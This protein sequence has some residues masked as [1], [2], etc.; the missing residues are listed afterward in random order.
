MKHIKQW[1]CALLAPVLALCLL[2]LPAARAATA[3]ELQAAAYS[4]YYDFL[5]AEISRIGIISNCEQYFKDHMYDSILDERPKGLLY[6]QLIDF[7]NSGVDELLIVKLDDDD[8]YGLGITDVRLQVYAYSGGK[9]VKIAQPSISDD[10]PD[11]E[12]TLTTG[13]DGRSYFREYTSWDRSLSYDYDYYTVVNGQWVKRYA[14]SELFHPDIYI[15]SEIHSS[16]G[17]YT[18]TLDNQSI[19]RD[20]YYGYRDQLD[21]TE[22][23]YSYTTL[24]SS[25]GDPIWTVLPSGTVT[26][27]MNTLR[28]YASQDTLL[29]YAPPASW[30]AEQVNAG[31]ADGIV[32]ASL[33]NSYA[34]PITR[35]EFCALAV[36]FYEK[37]TGTTIP[38]TASFS[39]T[40]DANVRKM[41]S[42]GV[43]NGIGGDK[44]APNQP[45]TREQAAVIPLPGSRPPS[46]WATWPPLWTIPSPPAP[47]PSPTTPRS[48]AGPAPRW[49]RCRP[50]ALWGA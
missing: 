20:Q 4:A 50:P 13:T 26:S 17:R 18:Y 34:K 48:P 49:A 32:P 15:S 43:V 27:V 7:D 28:P 6:A 37:H 14:L 30:A 44:F 46:F 10:Y 41:A 8:P 24:T 3:A 33:Q 9:A 36:N 42:I 38:Q 11:F 2:P 16:T 29:Y 1:L 40:S 25:D 19:S 12:F 47:P 22:V 39:D 5:Q 35:A 31:I 21:H 23:T 45:I